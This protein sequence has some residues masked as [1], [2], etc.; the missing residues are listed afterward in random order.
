MKEQVKNRRIWKLCKEMILA[1]LV[2]AFVGAIC[3]LFGRIL[4]A[5]GT[6]RTIHYRYLLPFLPLAGVAIIWLYHRFSKLSL[7]GM[8]LVMETGQKKRDRIPLLLVPLV[9]VC[10]WITHLFGGSAGREGVAVQIGGTLSHWLGRRMHLEDNGRVML[11]V[12][13]AAGFGGL[14]QTPLAAVFFAMEVIVFGFMDYE[15]LLPA[16][17]A[18]FTASYTSHSLG[19]EKFAVSLGTEVATLNLELLLRLVVLGIAFGFVG[20]GF[21]F[22]LGRAKQFIVRKVENP[23]YR[24][25][26]LAIPL[27][28]LLFLLWGGRYAG[29]GTNLIDSCF[30]VTGMDGNVTLGADVMAWDWICKFLLT[31]GTLAIGF[32]GGEVTPLFSIGATLGFVLGPVLGVPAVLAAALGYAA[33]F[34]SATNTLIAP[35]LIG[36]EVFGPEYTILFAVVCIVAYGVNGNLSIY[37]A[38][39]NA[40]KILSPNSQKLGKDL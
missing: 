18:S 13:M 16:M 14:F 28:I 8:T 33:V 11:I 5:I 34:G 1:L 3:A 6:F 12:G 20:G 21:A 19:L 9:M 15:A 29:L 32:Q 24:I 37:G 27:A 7:K 4:I 35:I 38:Q 40:Y 2:G 22:A 30:A 25:G 23:Y 39:A 10:T 36:V 17:V 26:V 31:I